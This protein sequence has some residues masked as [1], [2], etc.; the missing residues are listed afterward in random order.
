MLGR[1]RKTEKISLSIIVKHSNCWAYWIKNG[2]CFH[3]RVKGNG[4]GAKSSGRVLTVQIYS[5]TI[6]E[7][8]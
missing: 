7:K 5:D 6:K 8:I 4:H 2:K 3:G 1:K